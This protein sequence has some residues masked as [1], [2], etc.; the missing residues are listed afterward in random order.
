[1]KGACP[2][3]LV[4]DFPEDSTELI[5][6]AE[7]SWFLDTPGFA[8][9]YLTGLECRELKNYYPEFVSRQD[10]CRFPGCVHISE[11]GCEVKL[12]LQRREIHPMR[13]EN[14]CVL[15]EDL[16]QARR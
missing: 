1:M 7:N 11:P 3:V 6:F 4:P 9:L 16:K 13:Y 2:E 12:A 10:R 14:Y 15:Y 8:S 5:G